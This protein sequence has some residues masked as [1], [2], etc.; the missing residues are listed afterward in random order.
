MFQVSINSI[1]KNLSYS[2]N[3]TFTKT[4]TLI[5]DAPHPPAIPTNANL[6]AEIFRWKIRLMNPH[7]EVSKSQ[8]YIIADHK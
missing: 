1:Q 6:L 8:Q 4:L 7:F 5:V 2:E 3:K